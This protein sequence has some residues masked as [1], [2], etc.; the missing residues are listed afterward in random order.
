MAGPDADI[1]PQRRQ[2]LWMDYI[3]RPLN[4]G[5]AKKKTLK[6]TNSEG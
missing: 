6:S 2:P 4:E 1:L 5:K 3:E